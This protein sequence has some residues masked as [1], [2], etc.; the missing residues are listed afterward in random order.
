MVNILVLMMLLPMLGMGQ[1]VIKLMDRQLEVP[2]SEESLRQFVSDGQKDIVNGRYYRL[3]TFQAPLSQEW[4]ENLRSAGYDLL[5]Y[6]PNLTYIVSIAGELRAE[7]LIQA[8]AIHAMPLG[9]EIKQHPDLIAGMY[10]DYAM[11]DNK[12]LDLWVSFHEDIPVNTLNNYIRQAGLLEIEGYWFDYIRTVRVQRDQLQALASLP[13]V[14]WVSAIGP[15]DVPENYT[16]KTLHRSTMI[17]SSYS[18]GRRYDGSGVQVMMQD[19]G[20]IGP[21]I[22]FEGRVPLQTISFNYGDHGDHIAGTIMGAGNLN[23]R[24]QGMA[25]GAELYVYGA[26]SASYPGFANM[27][28]H[29]YLYNIRISS[30]SYS[31]G[32]NAGYTSLARTMD[33]QM[34]QLPAAM[35]VFSAGNDGFSDCGY[36]AGAGWGNITGGHKVG[37]NVIAVAN[38]DYKDDLSGSS[39]RGPAHDGRIKPDI[40]AKG[41]NV[42]ST[43]DPNLYTTKSGTSMSCPGVSGTL[44]QLYHAYRDLNSGNDPDGGLMKAVLLNSADDL[45]NPGPDFKTGWGRINAYRAVKTLEEQRFMTDS[46]VQGDTNTHIFTI[47]SQVSQFRVMVYWTDREAFVGSSKALVNDIDI[48]GMDALSSLHLPW[49]L[50][51]SPSPALLNAPATTGVDDLNNVEQIVINNPLQGTFSLD[52]IGKLV[53][54]G[55][56]RY[57]VVYEMLTDTIQLTYPVG[58]ESFEP[59]E[60]VTL[61][62]DAH[63][64]ATPFSLEYSLNN[65]LSWTS[66]ATSIPGSRRY[67]NWTLP[68]THTGMAR[69]RVSR[70]TESSESYESFSIMDVPLNMNIEW[71]C[72]DSF[73]LAWDSVPGAESYVVYMLGSKYMDTLG[74]TTE[75][76]YVIN[77]VHQSETKWVSVSAIGPNNAYGL[78]ANAIEKVPGIWNCAFPYDLMVEVLSPAP[79]HHP[80]CIDHSSVD[81]K[82]AISN[83]G[84]QAVSNIPVITTLGGLLQSETYA[85]TILPGETAYHTFANPLNLGTTGTFYVNASVQYPLDSNVYNNLFTSK[86]MIKNLPA[87]TSGQVQDF[88]AFSTCSVLSDC[89]DISCSLGGGW[90]NEVNN[91]LD[92]IDW[93]TVQ[94]IT[95]SSG[96]GPLGDHTQLDGS[97]NFVYLEASGDCYERTALLVSPCLDLSGM[98]HP[99]LD[100]WYSMYGSDMGSLHIDLMVDAEWMLDAMPPIVGNQGQGWNKATLD[101]GSYTG[102]K[103]AVRFRGITGPGNLSDLA[104]D[105]IA[106]V[107][108]TGLNEDPV[109]DLGLRFYPNPA[110]DILYLQLNPEGLQMLNLQILDLSGRD[111][112]PAMSTTGS[113]A[114]GMEIS[115]GNLPSGT[116]VI[117]VATDKVVAHEK[118]QVVR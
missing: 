26:A 118:F 16:A 85:G 86:V 3:V 45:D 61:R 17:S 10:P 22:D 97:G 87:I 101:L 70:G 96:T 19:D 92:D 112:L 114:S 93:R 116:Y 65:G 83:V 110:R 41:S 24:M 4:Q 28:S 2:R 34:R 89:E 99:V 46:L 33:Q 104:I 74:T 59:N 47:P 55:P 50:D 23:P 57:Y 106:L 79:G 107:D 69:L 88:D 117:R 102:A 64:D 72:K 29:Y 36:G 105:D 81:V 73:Q 67:F 43:T 115:L 42:T 20:I 95:P 113:V 58:G 11:P 103:V 9:A 32:C 27:V 75:T 78:R 91:D 35:H 51:H 109:R 13:F 6:I 44:A 68:N 39:S 1:G 15:E 21:H 100:F 82:I 66:I 80:A 76:F 53:P 77:G 5:Q 31:N 40:S 98:T 49:V 14:S 111:V 60:S 108:A 48:R 7:K 94:G 52:V 63:G 62:W 30:T 8:G 71:A 18:T 54:Q 38:L 37:K 90:N 56:Q 25:P 84:T 12:H